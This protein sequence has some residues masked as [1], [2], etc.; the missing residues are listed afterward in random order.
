LYHKIVLF[1][2]CL[3]QWRSD[4]WTCHYSNA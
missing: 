2:Q 1:F 3:W 4:G